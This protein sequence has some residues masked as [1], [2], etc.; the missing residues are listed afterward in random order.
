MSHNKSYEYIDHTADLG[1]RV[2]GKT[3]RDLCINIAKAIFETQIQGE[4]ESVKKMDI[5]ITS[6]SHDDLLIDW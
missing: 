4:I 2:Y 6:E 1:I 5:E 3:R